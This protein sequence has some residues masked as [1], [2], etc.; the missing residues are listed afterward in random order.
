DEDVPLV[1]DLLP[2]AYQSAAFV[3]NMVL[4]D[5]AM[6][7]ASRFD[8]F[9]DFVDEKE[10]YREVYERNAR[11]TT[12]AVLAWLDSA[13]DPERPL[14]L[15][16]HNIDPHGPNHPPDHW[17]RGFEHEG[18]RPIPI[19]RVPEYQREPGVTDGLSYVD[20]YDEEVAY[21]DSELGRLLDEYEKRR[22]LEQT[23]VVFT[24]DHGE[25][26]MEHERWFTH[27]Y[28]VYDEIV[29]VPLMIKGPGVVGG[30][31]DAPVSLLDI[32][33]T[34]LRFA[35]VE[36]TAAM[37][38]VD[39][40]SVDSATLG[41]RVVYA[42]ATE[43]TSFQ[44]LLQRRAAIHGSLKSVVEIT[45]PTAEVTRRWSYDLAAD[46]DETD[47]QP[48]PEPNPAGEALLE[49]TKLDPDP[50]GIPAE[51]AHGIR[52]GAPKVAPRAGSKAMER[53][54]ALGYAQ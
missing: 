8:F 54:K 22:S 46:P 53:L 18:S 28:Q 13:C 37:G 41:S 17:K 23:L 49:L 38:G 6:G 25:S 3:S 14:F 40:R 50:A 35:G 27:G 48:W 42:E 52:I 19:D 5:E 33:P 10:P 45:P 29:R 12:D 2:A 31:H 44:V 30:R 16:V 11:R 1:T 7:L 51:Y 9:D 26:M 34:L 4:T 24:A 15:W 39:L 43:E 47:P 20:F 32:A 21:V 36:P